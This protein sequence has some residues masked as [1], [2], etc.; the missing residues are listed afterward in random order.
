MDVATVDYWATSGRSRLH[1]A[2]AP[3]KIIAALLCLAAVVVLQNLF[4]V[5]AIFFLVLAAARRAGIPVGKF[6]LAAL[7]PAL[8]ALLFAIA[9]FHGDFIVPATTIAKAVTAASI[10]VLLIGTTPYPRLFAALRPVLPAVIVEALYITY[11]SIFILLRILGDA[12]TSMR[13]RGGFIGGGVRARLRNLA[14]ALALGAVYSFDVS[15]RTYVA[16]RLRG[17]SGRVSGEDPGRL[18]AGDVPLLAAAALT[19]AVGFFFRFEWRA[20][21]PYSWAPLA[22]SLAVFA[23]AFAVPLRPGSRPD[24]VRPFSETPRGHA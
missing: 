14:A 21:N 13:L 4:V 1:R 23:V 18:G 8:F 6:T 20:L 9:Q 22:L 11:R 10:V 3:A 12:M 15:E 19:S 17:Y 16:M 7:Y 5:L 2:S 24:P